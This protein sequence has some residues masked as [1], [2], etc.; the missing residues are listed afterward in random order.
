MTT[1][2]VDTSV[3]PVRD[4]PV[5]CWPIVFTVRSAD[6]NAGWEMTVDVVHGVRD[7]GNFCLQDAHRESTRL[8]PVELS[9]GRGFRHDLS[10]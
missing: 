2:A 1:L 10:R 6:G 9:G 4:V 8:L 5:S 3:D 7:L